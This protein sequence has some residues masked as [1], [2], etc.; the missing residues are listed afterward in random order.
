MCVERYCEFIERKMK[1][2]FSS[3]FVL[4]TI[5]SAPEPIHGYSIINK[6]QQLSSSAIVIQAGTV[7]PI[8]RNLED[9]GLIEHTLE[10]S[11]RGPERKVYILTSEGRRVI[12][13]FD[14]LIDTFIS[15]IQALRA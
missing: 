1:G 8:L 14:I 11:L 6:I 4:Y 2:G 5:K 15:T 9:L 10:R 13:R 3:I 12:D 7:Y